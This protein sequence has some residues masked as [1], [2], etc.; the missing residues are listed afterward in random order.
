MHVL[1]QS[2]VPHP[3]QKGWGADLHPTLW[4]NGHP[5]PKG[6]QANS[7]ELY[8]PLSSHQ[9]RLFPPREVGGA[10]YAQVCNLL[11]SPLSAACLS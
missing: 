11:T 5:P 1:E 9:D 7:Q 2:V 3:E 10:A 8:P 6:P 4:F